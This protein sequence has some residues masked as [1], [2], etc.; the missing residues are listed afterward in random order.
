MWEGRSNE[1]AIYN[2]RGVT[3]GDFAERPATYQIS[4]PRARGHVVAYPR[5]PTGKC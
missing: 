2:L 3:V 1:R 5:E 4:T